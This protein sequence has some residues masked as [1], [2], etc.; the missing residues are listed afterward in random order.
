MAILK[1]SSTPCYYK[2]QANLVQS[3]QMNNKLF[4]KLLLLLTF[5]LSIL[6]SLNT[7]SR[8]FYFEKKDNFISLTMSYSDVKKLAIYGG[9]TLPNLL[10]ILKENNFTS[11]ILREESIQDFINEG[12]AV[13]YQ[14]S[15]I[16][17][18]FNTGQ[19][20][21]YIL[22]YLNNKIKI[23][24]ERLYILIEKNKTL[25]AYEIFQF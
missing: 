17:N 22:N 3:F 2:N 10:N 25:I 19:N 20:N 5:S 4:L 6:L 16:I 13:L 11:I 8:R 12:R 18:M 21:R 23:Y 14:G 7:L 9:K 15:D 1:T 24:P